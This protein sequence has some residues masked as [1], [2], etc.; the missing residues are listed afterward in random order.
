MKI[1][2]VMVI[3][4]YKLVPFSRRINVIT[5]VGLNTHVSTCVFLSYTITMGFGDFLSL[6]WPYLAQVSCT[7]ISSYTTH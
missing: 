7:R 2:A 1:Y 3:L 6:T 5:V 4:A